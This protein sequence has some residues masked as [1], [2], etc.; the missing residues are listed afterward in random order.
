MDIFSAGLAFDVSNLGS[1][2]NG[3]FAL[4][5]LTIF[6]GP[7]NSGK[8]WTM[9][10]LYYFFTLFKI[11]KEF[12]EEQK[13]GLSK[14]DKIMSNRLSVLFNTSQEKL[15]N[16][17][18]AVAMT[19]YREWQTIAEHDAVNAFLMP[20]ERSGL[21]LFF[22]ELSTRRTALLH[23]ASRENIN[24]GE[25]LRD[26]IRSRYAVPIADYINWLNDLAD[27]QKSKS[28][29]FHPYAERLKRDL[30]RGAY[31]VD[32]RTGSIEFKPYQIKRDGRRTAT[33]GLHMTSSTVKSLFG[34]WFYL[35]HEARKG[36]ILM[37]DEPE[38]NIHPKNQRKIA[39]LL[40]KLVNAGL[41]IVISTHSDYII[42]ELNSLIMLNQ[43]KGRKFRK[44]Y[45]YGDNEVLKPEQIG[46]YLF[47]HQTIKLFDITPE[48][49]IYATTFDE[50]IHNLNTVNNDIYYSLQEQGDEQEQD[51]R[52]DD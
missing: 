3:S 2:R 10:S 51:E 12:P 46:A 49:G 21:H 40:A 7:N 37:I 39:R 45:K 4:K 25:L 22:R 34:L 42:R 41:N 6:C 44:K 16:A 30:A 35:E 20:S 31:K 48:D 18:F 9:Y 43:D 52:E 1:V 14:F 32:A 38:L 5:P 11:W 50:V 24:I 47:D 23:H 29:D 26:V 13:R 17:E 33:M 15:R 28:E 27:K 36:N 19:D 8:T